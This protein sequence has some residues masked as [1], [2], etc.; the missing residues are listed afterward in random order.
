MALRRGAGGVEGHILRGTPMVVLEPM[1]AIGSGWLP[2][3]GKKGPV[4]PTGPF[5][6]CWPGTLTVGVRPAPP[7]GPAVGKATEAYCYRIKRGRFASGPFEWL[8]GGSGGRAIA[9][10][11]IA[12]SL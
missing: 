5:R 10:S 12:D 1:V 7:N 2:K 3:A 11:L 4:C 6:R 9:I 8:G